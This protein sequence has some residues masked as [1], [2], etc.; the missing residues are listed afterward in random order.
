MK[1]HI[2]IGADPGQTGAIAFFAMGTATRVIDMPVSSRKAGGEEVNGTLLA[3]EIRGELRYMTPGQ[4]AIAYVEAVHAMPK[5]GVNSVFR[6]GESFG[7]L[8]GVLQALSIPVVLVPPARWKKD[9]GLI[10]TEKDVARTLAIQRW[11][12]MAHLLARKRDIGRADS[13]LIGAYG[14]QQEA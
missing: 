11:P 1:S 7:R 8:I 13:L 12:Q 3:T 14:V 10:G 4:T 5:Q 9:A 2:V 6:F